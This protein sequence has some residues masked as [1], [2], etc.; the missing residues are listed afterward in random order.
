[1]KLLLRPALALLTSTALLAGIAHAADAPA[2][3]PADVAKGQAIATQVCGA[4]HA[5]DGARGAPANPIIAGQHP[6]YLAKQLAEFKSGQ[7]DNAIMKGFASTLSPTDMQNVSTYYAGK[8]S[9][10]G[11]AK[12]KTTLT[13]GEKIYRAGVADRN[14]PACAGCHTP[15]GA[16]IPV[17]FPRLAGQHADY[18]EKQ[19]LAFR[20]G[21]R[22]NNAPMAAIAARLTDKEINAVSD[23]VAGLR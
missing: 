5:A 1:M 20:S 15:S 11:F 3:P 19:L 23:Y 17:Q 22:A 4:C 2:A 10:P 7:R 21:S 6:E 16:G 14:I 13:L 12:S 18:T 8:T 9:K